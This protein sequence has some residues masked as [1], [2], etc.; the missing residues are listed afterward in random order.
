MKLPI[1]RSRYVVLPGVQVAQ[2]VESL[3]GQTG[4]TV[5]VVVV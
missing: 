2:L 3:Q 5:V 4:Q 1:A